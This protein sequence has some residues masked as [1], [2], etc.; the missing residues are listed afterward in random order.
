M[1]RKPLTTRIYTADP[2]AHEFEGKIYIYPSHDLDLD[3]QATDEGDE[4]QMTDYHILSMDSPDSP[5]KDHGEALHVNNVP[6]AVSQMW[7]PDAA[8]KNG[9]YYFYFPAR[10]KNGIFRI[11]VATSDKPYGPFKPEQN[12]INGSFSIDPCSF[13]DDDGSAYVYFGGLWGG[14]LEKWTTGSFNPDGKEP[15]ENSPA[16]CPRVAK[17]TGDMLEFSETPR[18]IVIL[19]ETGKPLT[20][21]DEDRRYFEG[22]W[23]HKYNGTYYFSY[24][25][26]TTHYIVYAT[27]DNPYGPFTYRGRILNPV[28]GWTTHHSI[29][30]FK[31]EWYLFYHDSEYSGGINQKRTVKMAELKFNPDGTIQTLDP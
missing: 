6:W 8:F 25:T 29:M 27:G 20:A 28:I 1:S 4:Y 11:G 18:E 26:G 22:P 2:S 14:Q 12:Y 7:A 15:P 19:D 31:G 16:V 9:V 23:L 17:M 5:V 24:S 10:D 30:E 3:A 21:G 13:V